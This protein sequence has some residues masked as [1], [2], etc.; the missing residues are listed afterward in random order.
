M[1]LSPSIYKL[2]KQTLSHSLS[3]S[4]SLVFSLV[5]SQNIFAIKIYCMKK[6]NSVT[7]IVSDWKYKINHSLIKMSRFEK[8]F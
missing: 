3:L 2:K 5:F 7:D 8:Y 4:L 1:M 6:L